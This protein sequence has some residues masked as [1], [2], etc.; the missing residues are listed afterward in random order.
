MTPD[1]LAD[2]HMRAE[3][4]IDALAARQALQWIEANRLRV[5]VPQT[6]DLLDKKNVLPIKLRRLWESDPGFWERFLGLSGVL[7][8]VRRHLGEAFYLIRSAAFI[9]YPN[10]ASTV[11]WHRD[12]DLWGHA[13]DAGLTAWIPLTP[14]PRESGCLQFLPGSHLR[15]PGRLY[16]DLRHPY[17]K[18]MDVRGMGAPVHVN[19]EVGDCIV[20]D[21]RAVHASGANASGHERIGL[22]L[23]FAR[24][25]RS[26][27]T[28]P[29]VAVAGD[30]RFT[31]VPVL[32]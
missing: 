9:K 31:P 32:A 14:V 21:K 5:D 2:G 7:P 22:V 11:G 10:S 3:G 26:A 17:H 1:Y 15:P 19:A 27:L 6:K 30:G 25:P 16:W 24:C 13:C 28:E 4:A 12:E 8:L 18:V 20:M 29:A 23:A